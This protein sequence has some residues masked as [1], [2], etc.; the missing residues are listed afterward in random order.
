MTP[1]VAALAGMLIV[2]GVLGLIE[3][4][5]KVPVPVGVPH[6]KA[7]VG[8]IP[9]RILLVAVTAAVAGVAIALLTGWV[10]AIVILPV[11]AWGLPAL[12]A[13]PAEGRVIERLEALAEWTRNLSGVL[14]V[15]MGLESALVETLRSTPTAIRP[16]VAALASRIRSRWDTQDALRRFADDFNDPTGDLVAATLILAARKQADGLG[17]I[18]SGLAESVSAE[19]T[20]RR[21]LEADRAKPRQTARLVTIITAV[22]LAVMALSG[23]YLEQYHSPVGQLIFLT[24][25]G[26]YASLLAVMKKMSTVKP[27]PRFLGST[28]RTPS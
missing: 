12:L 25:L 6:K 26:A 21:Q 23:Q 18:L 8:R 24:L 4:L 10:I 1:L 17:Q 7:R 20:A 11:A 27:L 19:V 28:S 2:G 9:R 15:G 14:R 5:R 3:G 22:M 13:R 16:E